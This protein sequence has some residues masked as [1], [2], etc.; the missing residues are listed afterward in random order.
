MARA[1][2]DPI[3]T[4]SATPYSDFDTGETVQELFLQHLQQNGLPVT[5]FLVNGVKLQ[6]VIPRFDHETIILR[7]DGHTQ[8]VYKHA[9]STI[10]P[11]APLAVFAQDSDSD[12]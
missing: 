5:V 11:V 8:L 2:P 7:R 4:P 9:V 6:G 1:N 10:M 3:P 12:L